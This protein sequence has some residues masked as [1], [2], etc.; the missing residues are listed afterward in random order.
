MAEEFWKRQQKEY[1]TYIYEN[2]I[3]YT[4]GGFDEITPRTLWTEAKYSNP[5]YG[6]ELLKDMFGDK[7]GVF[8]YPKSIYT[9]EDMITLKENEIILDF[10]CGIRDNWACGN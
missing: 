8:D 2:G 1:T 4:P 7:G 3:I 9:L 10:F 6:T 5:E